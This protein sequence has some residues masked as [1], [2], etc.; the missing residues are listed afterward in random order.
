MA[1]SL[2]EANGVSTITIPSGDTLNLNGTVKVNGVSSGKKVVV[3]SVVDAS[4]G[5]TAQTTNLMTV[6]A[7]AFIKE[8]MAVV[9]T[10]FNGA[11][12]TT[13]DVGISGTA[14]KYIHHT[15]FNAGGSANTF[16]SMTGGTNNST[17]HTDY[18]ASST[19]L[20]ATWT[21]TTGASAGNVTVTCEYVLA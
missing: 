15:D 4:A 20:I 18:R 6:P 11:S 8:V 9:N 7:G 3:A 16:M 12:T 5:G 1:I 2:T 10:P 14:S 13:L 21:N 17:K 19:Q